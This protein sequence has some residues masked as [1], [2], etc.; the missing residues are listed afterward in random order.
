VRDC[1]HEC[2]RSLDGP[3]G[4]PAL[5]APPGGLYASTRVRLF[6]KLEVDRERLEGLWDARE[7]NPLARDALVCGVAG[8]VLPVAAPVA[9]VLGLL[10]LHRVNPEAKPPIGK[11]NQALAGV[12]LGG[13]GLMFWAVVL[14]WRLSLGLSPLP[15]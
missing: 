9:M 7:N 13:T 10:G 5:P 4:R 3:P 15:W 8:L 12:V 2:P 14:Q 1:A 6:F 11:G